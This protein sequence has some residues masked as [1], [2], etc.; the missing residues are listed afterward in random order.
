MNLIGRIRRSFLTGLVLITPLAVTVF[1]LQFVFAR[2][3]GVLDP[4]IQGTRLTNYT[5]NNQLVAQVLA[6]VLIAVAIAALG[7]VASWGIGKRLFGGLER[8]LRLVPLVRTI[9]FG[10]QQVGESLVERASGYDSVV[11][12]EFPRNGTYSLGFVT[13]RAPRSVRRATGEDAYNVFVP[14]SPNPT[15][16]ALVMLPGEDIHEL[17]MPVRKGLRLLVTTGLSAEELAVEKGTLDG[18][19]PERTGVERPDR[20]G[21]GGSAGAGA[22]DGDPE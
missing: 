6:A 21:T 22:G 2:V 20:P 10:V 11:L 13:N 8:G 5:A 17:D 19:A 4:V 1:V 18:R 3:T 16:G 9:Y 15:A 14:N 7:F 12:V